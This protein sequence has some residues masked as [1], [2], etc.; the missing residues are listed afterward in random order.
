M[1]APVNDAQRAIVSRDTY[2]NSVAPAGDEMRYLCRFVEQQCE[3]SWPALLSKGQCFAWNVDGIAMQLG[4]V[5]KRQGYSEF[6]A[7]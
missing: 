3:W 4:D 5:Y 1:S 6:V 7:S 2:G